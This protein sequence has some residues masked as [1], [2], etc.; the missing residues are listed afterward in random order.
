MDLGPLEYLSAE[1]FR[2]NIEGY[3]FEENSGSIV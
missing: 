3:Y 2:N 1:V